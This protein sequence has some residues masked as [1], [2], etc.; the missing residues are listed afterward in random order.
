[1]VPDSVIPHDSSDIEPE[2]EALFVLINFD[3]NQK[4]STKIQFGLGS[5]Y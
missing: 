2:V 3:G 5:H 1:M 4:V